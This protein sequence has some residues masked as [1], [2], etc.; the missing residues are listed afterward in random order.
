MSHTRRNK[1]QLLNRVRR[2]GGQV[3]AVE[4]ALMDE[5][6]CAKILQL[7]ASVRGATNGLMAELIEDHLR[8][9]V[10]GEHGEQAESPQE[11]AEEIMS[12]VRAYL[13]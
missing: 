8:N 2:L 12:I 9:H 11:A 7:V 4:R 1:T 5:A 3:E 13:K 6:D 10:L